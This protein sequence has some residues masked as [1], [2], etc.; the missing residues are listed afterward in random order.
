MITDAEQRKMDSIA[1]RVRTGRSKE[2]SAEE[3]QWV[4][5]L[6]KREDPRLPAKLYAAAQK[7]GLNLDGIAVSAGVAP[8]MN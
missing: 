2:V 3:R 5:D 7:E 4:V 8:H 6:I 1:N